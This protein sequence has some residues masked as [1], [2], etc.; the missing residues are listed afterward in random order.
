MPDR[1][2]PPPAAGLRSRHPPSPRVDLA[3]GAALGLLL[4]TLVG[5]SATPIVSTVV[6]ALVALLAGLFGLS[7]KLSWAMQSGGARRLVAFGLAA[8]L[9]TPA[10]ILV[11]TYEWLSP[12]IDQQ[13]QELRRIGVVDS[14]EQKDLLLFLHFGIQPAGRSLSVKDG[15]SGTQ[16]RQGVLYA[17]PAEFCNEITR[18]RVQ[19]A[20][21]ADY[22][23]LF[24]SGRDELRRIGEA[25]AALSPDR[26]KAV[27]EAAPVYLCSRS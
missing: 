11:R 13:R 2:T 16:T 3:A 7:D 21:P 8:T 10:A 17:A 4:G 6:T 5:L 9:A 14:L 18:L 15:A 19:G 20:P 24:G 12:S 1:E 23:A 22:L 25:I 27:L 26:Q